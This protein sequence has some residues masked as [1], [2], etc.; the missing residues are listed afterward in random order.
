[1]FNGASDFTTCAA[2]YNNVNGTIYR[3]DSPTVFTVRYPGGAP[4]VNNGLNNLEHPSPTSAASSVHS[5]PVGT[6]LFAGARNFSLLGAEVNNAQVDMVRESSRTT[7]NLDLVQMS[8]QH[9]ATASYYGAG[10]YETAGLG[11]YNDL[12]S[13]PSVNYHGGQYNSG[14]VYDQHQP[15]DMS[16]HH[17]GYAMAPHGRRTSYNR[18][19]GVSRQ[20]SDSPYPNNAGAETRRFKQ[21]VGSRAVQPREPKKRRK[22]KGKKHT[23]RTSDKAECESDEEVQVESP[24]AISRTQTY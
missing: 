16:G 12:A 3:K 6:G 1:M 14:R 20:N 7:M 10:A 9:A 23:Q 13:S 8:S 15:P 2:E 18:P 11:S 22:S 24:H 4:F 5:H 19:G 21:P 17:R